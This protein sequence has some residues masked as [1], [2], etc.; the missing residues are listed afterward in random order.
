MNVTGLINSG[1]SL[2]YKLNYGFVPNNIEIMQII[3][4]QPFYS[5]LIRSK[6]TMNVHIDHD[7]KQD[8][9][10]YDTLY[11]YTILA[12]SFIFTTCIQCHADN[13]ILYFEI[14]N[15]SRIVRF[16]EHTY[17]EHLNKVEKISFC[18]KRIVILNRFFVY[19]PIVR[20]TG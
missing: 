7:Q 14:Y 2:K 13:E 12:V 6:K 17:T 4:N 20:V 15:I 1:Y 5:G 11:T 16:N 19:F 10:S 8:N 9:R 3:I 18:Q